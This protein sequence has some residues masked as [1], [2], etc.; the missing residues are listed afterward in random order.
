MNI[1]YLALC[2]LPYQ[3]LISLIGKEKAWLLMQER[4]RSF[5]DF[6]QS[7]GKLRI[8]YR[9]L[10][11]NTL[12]RLPPFLSLAR[13]TVGGV[14]ANDGL[15]DTAAINAA[16]FDH[17]VWGSPI[18]LLVEPAST[19]FFP[20]AVPQSSLAWFADFATLQYNQTDDPAGGNNGGRLTIGA[21]GLSYA[22]AGQSLAAALAASSGSIF[23]RPTSAAEVGKRVDIGLYNNTTA[24]GLGLTTI[25]LHAHDHYHRIPVDGA[26]FTAGDVILLAFGNLH[27]FGGTGNLAIGNKVDCWGAQLEAAET[28]LILTS[29]SELTR[30]ADVLTI[31]NTAK[32]TVFVYDPLDGSARTTV[33]VTAGNQPSISGRILAAWQV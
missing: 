33:T 7:C 9:P 17:N 30:A 8:D 23:L 13:A 24:A 14:I 29:G 3:G 5:N 1:D 26:G 2:R 27:P 32:D 10:L 25:T 28:S 20:L 31:T 12:G 4:G 19:N 18:G 15:Y 21:E 16:R 22:Y 6:V 11:A